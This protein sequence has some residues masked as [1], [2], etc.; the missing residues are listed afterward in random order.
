MHKGLRDMN[1][2]YNVEDCEVYKKV[3]SADWH[4]DLV[5][6]LI[7]TRPTPCSKVIAAF[8][9]D[10]LTH[11][12]LIVM[13]VFLEACFQVKVSRPCRKCSTKLADDISFMSSLKRGFGASRKTE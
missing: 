11:M 8:W 9:L 6:Y 3:E 7:R 12:D 5:Q 13:R 10:S 4:D 1:L 2:G